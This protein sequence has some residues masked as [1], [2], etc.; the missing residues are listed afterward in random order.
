MIHEMS[1]TPYEIDCNIPNPKPWWKTIEIFSVLSEFCNIGIVI[2]IVNLFYTPIRFIAF[3]AFALI[4][5]YMEAFIY[6]F[7]A[8]IR[9]TKILGRILFNI[10][11]EEDVLQHN[12]LQTT[13]DLIALSLF[14]A[15]V[16]LLT[17][18]TSIYAT[19]IAWV[20]SFIGLIVIDYSD[21][22]LTKLAS[23]ETLKNNVLKLLTMIQS[24][25]TEQVV[26]DPQSL[27]KAFNELKLH[28]FQH[29]I[30]N[31]SFILYNMLLLGVGTLLICS[32]ATAFTSGL[33]FLILGIIAKLASAYLGGIA[34]MR[35]HNYLKTKCQTQNDSSLAPL[36]EFIKEAPQRDKSAESILI[37]YGSLFKMKLE[38][39]IPNHQ[40]S[41]NAISLGK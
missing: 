6:I 34:I 10:Q 32:S 40:E 4:E 25:M 5:H 14:I 26:E 2:G 36:E 16:V 13:L 20:V 11:F 31:K 19:T 27:M 39:Y 3:G 12:K 17:A 23:R 1:S 8:L 18:V 15:T 28:Y 41:N 24:Q 7:K 33:T 21:Y 29:E 22:Y 38:N 30:K 9:T 35:F 37:S